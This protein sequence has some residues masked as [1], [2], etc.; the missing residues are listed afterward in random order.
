MALSLPKSAK[1]S[2][3]KNLHVLSVTGPKDVVLKIK[4]YNEKIVNFYQRNMKKR[5]SKQLVKSRI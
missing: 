5:V 1:D 4:F 3:L 2:K